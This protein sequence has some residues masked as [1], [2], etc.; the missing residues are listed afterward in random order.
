MAQTD[1]YTAES[2]EA[3]SARVAELKA[4]LEDDNASA[5]EKVQAMKDLEAAKELLRLAGGS[6]SGDD[7]QNPGGGSTAGGSQT[8]SSGGSQTGSGDKAV[9]TGD[10]SNAALWAAAAALAG[11]AL[12]TA[13]KKR[14]TEK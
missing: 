11:A 7:Q 4:I 8:G 6:G 3:Y 10:T 9:Q 12:V 14:R 5:A 13:G 2:L 1:K